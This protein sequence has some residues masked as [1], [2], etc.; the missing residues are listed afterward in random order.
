MTE[1]VTPVLLTGGSGSRLWPLS[2]SQYPKQFLNL[3][4]PEHSLLQLTLLRART[5]TSKAP[6]LVGNEAHR[7]LIAEQLR[8]LDIRPEA[9]LLE[10]CARNTAPAVALAALHALANDEDPL[11]LI[12]PADHELPDAEAFSNAVAVAAAEA[13]SGKL[14]AFGVKPSRVETGYGYIRAESSNGDDKVNA[15]R[16]FIEKPDQAEAEAYVASGDYFWNAG[17]FLFRASSYLDELKA[18]APDILEQCREA[19]VASQADGEFLRLGEEAFKAC[20]ADSI[21]YAIMER[22]E[23]AA[24]VALDTAWSDVGAWSALW[25]NHPERD[26]NDNVA[27][28]DVVLEDVHGSY[29]RSESRLVSALDV[30]DLIVIET[31]DAVFI[32]PKHRAQAVRTI[33]QRLEKDRREETNFHRRVYRPWGS[34]ESLVMDHGFQVKRIIVKP[35]ASLSLQMHHHRAEHWTIVRGT[36][37]VTRGEEQFLLSEDQ[38]T[39]IPLGTQHRLENPGVIPLEVIEVQTGNYLGEDDIVR[40]DDKYGR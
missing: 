20:R 38:S 21:D 15:I 34:Y 12:L 10:P 33:V 22:T 18:L 8:T 37:R 1:D 5:V 24:M 31:A 30:E 23:R 3:T 35:G 26:D 11:L 17:L 40:F 9:I 39:Y 2:R 4:H 14:I 32:A 27:W 29:I 25:E 13:R 6:L 28:G 7:F 19:Y 16:N 36:A